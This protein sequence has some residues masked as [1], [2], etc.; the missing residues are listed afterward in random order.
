M[1]CVSDPSSDTYGLVWA[2]TSCHMVTP[3]KRVRREGL[4]WSINCFGSAQEHCSPKG[5]NYAGCA[6]AVEKAFTVSI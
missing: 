2:A 5:N 3:E 4:V 6:C 1:Q